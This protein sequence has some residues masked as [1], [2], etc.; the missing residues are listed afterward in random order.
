MSHPP[1][2][3]VVA[4][5]GYDSPLTGDDGRSHG[6]GKG[7]SETEQEEK[8]EELVSKKKN[9]EKE[10]KAETEREAEMEMEMEDDGENEQEKEG[11]EEEE[12]LARRGPQALLKRKQSSYASNKEN[13]DDDKVEIKQETVSD[14]DRAVLQRELQKSS[15]KTQSSESEAEKTENNAKRFKKNTNDISRGRIRENPPATSFVEPVAKR[16]R[17]RCSVFST[18]RVPP[19]SSTKH[20]H[21]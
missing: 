16:T 10:K 13:K 8:E 6:Q 7:G 21:R 4:N 1:L 11:K 3:T 12:A 9:E 14:D 15:E 2:T 19:S 20:S 17:S 5:Q 18:T